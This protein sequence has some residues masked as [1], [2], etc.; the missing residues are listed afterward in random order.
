MR[1]KDCLAGR[2]HSTDLEHGVQVNEMSLAFSYLEKW[3]AGV[4]RKLIQPDTQSSARTIANSVLIISIAVSVAAIVLGTLPDLKVND[5]QWVRAII[6]VASIIFT[7]EYACRIW[8]APEGD[9]IART[10]AWPARWYYLRSFLGVIDLLV[11]LPSYIGLVA[12]LGQDYANLLM[13]LAL[14]K[15][16]RY[17]TSLSLFA[18]VF[19]AEGR[20]LLSGMM[21]MMVLL[22]L[23]SGVMFVLERNSQPDVFRSIPHAMWWAIVTMATVGYGD[24]IPVTPLG[25]VFG[26]FTM[27]L[28]IAMFA[29]PAGILANGF[30]TE[31][32]KRDFLV[33]WQTVASL[34]LFKSL[35]ASRIA[36][37]ARLL[38]TQ[39]L[40]ARQVVVRRGEAADAMFFIMA[41]E[42]E[43][44]VQPTPI[45]L[46][47]GKYFGEIALVKDV[48]RTAT[49]IT[50]GEC[51]LL[52][53]DAKDFRQLILQ[54]PDLRAAIERVADERLEQMASAKPKD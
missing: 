24:I 44:E 8:V 27:L 54:A 36:D 33:T 15:S 21:A 20:A 11:I 17:A 49:V 30:A 9:P 19:R 22:V 29:V 2:T 40:P 31:V 46:G 41:G 23:V 53:L 5:R 50:I 51:R 6:G 34:P 13:L 37:I 4:Y 47:K 35:D 12:P 39:V 18:A 43:V 48:L 3:R 45:R 7:I 25:K 14:L 52:S 28:G 16:A 10:G 1:S 42:V 26:G 32:R 38:K